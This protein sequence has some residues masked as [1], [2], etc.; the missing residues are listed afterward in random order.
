VDYDEMRRIIRDDEPPTPSRR[1]TTL[2]QAELS[3]VAEQRS[4]EPRKLSQHVR[5][6]L[7]WGPPWWA[8]SRLNDRPASAPH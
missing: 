2:A 8:G 5:G 3:T 1:L 4:I 7:D 6:E